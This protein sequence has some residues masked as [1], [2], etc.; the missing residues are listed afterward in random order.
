MKRIALFIAT[1]IA[2]LFVLNISM[3]VLGL[4]PWLSSQGINMGSLLLF[5]AVYM[6]GAVCWVFTNPKGASNRGIG[7]K[8]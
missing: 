2:I 3:R 5:A 4:D 8:G 1:N 7:R 6:A